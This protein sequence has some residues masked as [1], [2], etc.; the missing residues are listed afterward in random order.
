MGLFPIPINRF[1][2]MFAAR[3]VHTH[4][5]VRTHTRAHTRTHT[6][7]HT[8]AHLYM[9]RCVRVNVAAFRC[10]L[11]TRGVYAGAPFEIWLWGGGGVG[12]IKRGRRTIKDL[13]EGEKKIALLF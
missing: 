12:G 4:K 1:I 3:Y 5:H 8:R 11:S 13:P 7:V 10:V 2:N 6:H 9:Y